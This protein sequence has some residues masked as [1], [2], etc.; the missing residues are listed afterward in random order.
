MIKEQI[1]AAIGAGRSVFC[2]SRIG[3]HIIWQKFAQDREPVL[4]L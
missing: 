3:G 1:C 2:R 4:F